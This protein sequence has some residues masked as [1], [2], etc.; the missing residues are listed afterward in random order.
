MP[1]QRT[2]ISFIFTTM[3]LISFASA[4]G[5]PTPEP[6]ANA[7]PSANTEP[8]TGPEAQNVVLPADKFDLTHWKITVPVDL[9]GDN[10]VDSISQSDLASYSHPDF[11]HLD[12]YQRLVFTAPNK[13]ITTKNSS[14][15]R[16]E[17]R[18]MSK[19]PKSK[20]SSKDHANNFSLKAHPKAQEFAS[21]GGKMEATLHVDAVAL[22]AGKP[23]KFPA[24][25]AVVGQIHAVKFSGLHVSSGWG[26]EPLKIY[27]KKWPNHEKGSVFWT[28]ERNLAKADPQRRD[29]AYPVWGNTWDISDNPGD[30]GIALGEEFSYTVNVYQNIMTLTFETENHETIRYEIDLSNNIDAN[31]KVDSEDNPIGYSGDSMYFKAGIYDQCSTSDADGFWYAAC[32][33]TGDWKTD[34]ANGDFAR[35]TFSRLV[36]SDA[37][38]N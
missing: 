9:N 21:I 24:Y 26:N 20:I 29:I 31:G 6:S 13:A 23:E 12:Q 32:A 38:P 34:H 36:V 15:T 3:F 7:E 8:S 10:K 25:S 17:L 27:Y 1:F 37:T 22:N 19:E 33:G 30:Q 18:Y 5:S 2:R 11:F 28:Y 16:S 35:A 14:N 4:C